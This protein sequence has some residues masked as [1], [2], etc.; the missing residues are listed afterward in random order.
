MDLTFHCFFPKNTMKSKHHSFF[1]VSSYL[2][3]VKN[4]R[5]L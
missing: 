3:L 4:L 1:N 5:L 2:I